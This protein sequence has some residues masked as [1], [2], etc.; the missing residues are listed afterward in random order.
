MSSLY[1]SRLL[2]ILILRDI[3]DEVGSKGKAVVELLGKYD[4][5]GTI[6]SCSRPSRITVGHKHVPDPYYES[7]SARFEEVFHQCVR[8]VRAFLD[9]HST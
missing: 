4:P 2:P 5:E 3:K 8:C 9:K 1:R 7:G 6:H